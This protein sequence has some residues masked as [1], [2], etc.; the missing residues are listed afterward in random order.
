ME[1]QQALRIE[2]YSSAVEVKVL[3]DKTVLPAPAIGPEP[4]SKDDPNYHSVPDSRLE[5]MD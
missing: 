2:N 5:K 1:M 4:V 3:P